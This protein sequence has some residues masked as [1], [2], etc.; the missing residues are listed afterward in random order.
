MKS[1][2]PAGND[3]VPVRC[4]A[5]YFLSLKRDEPLKS[6]FDEPLGKNATGKTPTHKKKDVKSSVG[7]VCNRSENP[8]VP[9]FLD[10]PV[11]L[12]SSSSAIYPILGGFRA[13]TKKCQMLGDWSQ[14]KQ[15]RQTAKQKRI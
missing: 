12:M 13:T 5:L 11:R 15:D 9:L 3:E 14:N 10:S 1:C 4:R 7:T 6:I 8:A 2:V